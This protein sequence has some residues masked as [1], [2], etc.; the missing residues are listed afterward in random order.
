MKPTSSPLGSLDNLACTLT[1]NN[2]KVGEEFTFAPGRTLHSFTPAKYRKVSTRGY[3]YA[4][5]L[6]GE[7]TFWT[8][9]SA[10]VR[11]T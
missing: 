10:E 1:F 11:R 6:K 4:T 8:T 2:I 9:Q 7:Q 5:D 3:V